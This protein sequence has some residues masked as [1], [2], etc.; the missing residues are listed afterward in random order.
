TLV[1]AVVVLILTI[2]LTIFVGA[3]TKVISINN[4]F[5]LDHFEFVLR[6]V[7]VESIG[8]TTLLATIATPIAGIL[9][10]LIAFLV[11]R[12]QFIGQSALDFVTMLGIAVPGT[13][14]GIGYL[15]MYN[16]PV[17]IVIPWLGSVEEPFAL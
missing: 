2:Y 7:G 17:E 4:D 15:L 14:L 5:T 12:K 6:G 8:D 13:V 3:F 10:I 16:S 11:V 9:G 1:M